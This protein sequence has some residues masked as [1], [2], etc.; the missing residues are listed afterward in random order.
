MNQN[1]KEIL[2]HYLTFAGEKI[3]FIKRTSVITLVPTF[4]F[5]IFV[6]FFFMA[7]S[8]IAFL[9]TFIYL[10]VFVLALLLTITIAALLNLKIIIE[11]YFHIYIVTNKKILEITYIPLSSYNV[12]DVLLEQVKCTEI[13]IR[14]NGFLRE[15]LG[16]GDIAMTFDRPTHNQEFI[17][18]NITHARQLGSLLTQ[19]LMNSSVQNDTQQWYKS[20][21]DHKFYMI[22]TIIPKHAV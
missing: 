18:A 4:I 20:N 5:V 12:N 1:T 6:A 9:Y 14:M 22:D 19:L 7:A 13:D 3:H 17:L 11:W 2:K 8:Y 16:I 10:H 15:M 21:S